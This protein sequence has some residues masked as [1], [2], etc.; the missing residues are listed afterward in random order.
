[1][2]DNSD[3]DANA[4]R[5]VL[6]GALKEMLG[7]S[8]HFRPGQVEAID[9]ALSGKDCL[10]MLPT[11]AG[12]SLVYMLPAAMRAAEEEPGVTIVISPLLSL[13]RDQTKR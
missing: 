3:E 1:M 11:G 13:L 2:M 5:S 6:D 9:A 7:P 12:K 10:A 8:A 4:L